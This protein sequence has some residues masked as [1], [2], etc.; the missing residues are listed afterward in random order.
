MNQRARTVGKAFP[1]WVDVPL[2]P[3]EP[4]DPPRRR[5]PSGWVVNVQLLNGQTQQ[6]LPGP[7][8]YNDGRTRSLA[9]LDMLVLDTVIFH[10]LCTASNLLGSELLFEGVYG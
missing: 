2:P 10:G 9:E 3:R 8:H 1:E 4:S 6:L 7:A 5:S